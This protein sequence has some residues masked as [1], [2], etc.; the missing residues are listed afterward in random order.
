MKK[1]ISDMTPE[2]CSD[3][4]VFGI[5]K[6]LVGKARKKQTEATAATALV[7]EA[8]EDMCIDPEEIS[9]DAEN[10]DNLKEAICCYI[11]YGE[12]SIAGIMKEVREA[13]GKTD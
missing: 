10:A 8:L 12:Y 4:Q 13:Y 1:P 9:S 3:E 5:F 7:F 2:E 6:R 11:G